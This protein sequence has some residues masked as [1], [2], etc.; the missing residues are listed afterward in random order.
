D[1]RW[2]QHQKLTAMNARPGEE[3]GFSLAMNGNQLAVGA[4]QA[5]RENALGNG[6]AYAFVR[7]G[8]FWFEQYELRPT[9]QQWSSYLGALGHSVAILDNAII[10]AA[11]F[12]VGR[13]TGAPLFFFERGAPMPNLKAQAQGT[14]HM[15]EDLAAERTTLF[16]GVPQ[17]TSGRVLRYEIQNLPLYT[18]W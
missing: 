14:L 15:G 3:F 7:S 1:G 17:A 16:A 4:P 6:T 13:F 12:A 10:V 11:P 9:P 18:G 8:R 5:V 2:V